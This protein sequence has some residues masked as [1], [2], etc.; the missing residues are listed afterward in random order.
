M[1]VPLVFPVVTFYLQRVRRKFESELKSSAFQTTKTSF[2]PPITHSALILT[3]E[4]R[5]FE[6]MLTTPPA[7][8]SLW[9]K[10]TSGVAASPS[11][12]PNS[13]M[14]TERPQQEITQSTASLNAEHK[15]RPTAGRFFYLNLELGC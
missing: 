1:C 5:T 6:E 7:A 11:T 15:E 8:E 13:N 10:R 9:S 14:S 4:F 12:T 2:Q 3:S